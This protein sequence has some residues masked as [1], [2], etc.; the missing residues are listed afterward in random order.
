MIAMLN[1]EV[2]ESISSCDIAGAGVGMGFT[3]AMAAAILAG[4]LS[5]RILSRNA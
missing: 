4:S 2:S 3:A 1:P 5:N